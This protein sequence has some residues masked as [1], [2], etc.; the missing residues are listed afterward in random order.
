LRTRTKGL[1]ADFGCGPGHTTKFPYD[2]SLESIIGIDISARMI[3]VVK[4]Q[5]PKIKFEMGDILNINYKSDYLGSVLAF[6]AIVHFNFF[7]CHIHK[8]VWYPSYLFYYAQGA[9][10]YS[11]LS[12]VYLPHCT[13]NYVHAKR[14]YS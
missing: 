14:R 1:C 8:C 10:V 7:L 5:F 6:Y 4:R 9:V 2:H 3:D 11:A 12:V 13:N